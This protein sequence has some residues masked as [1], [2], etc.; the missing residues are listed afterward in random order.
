MYFPFLPLHGWGKRSAIQPQA[1]CSEFP[2]KLARVVCAAMP[3]RDAACGAE[4]SGKNVVLRANGLLLIILPSL[5]ARQHYGCSI[6]VFTS[7]R[8]PRNRSFFFGI[9]RFVIRRGKIPQGYLSNTTRLY[10][11]KLIAQLS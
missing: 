5:Y 4:W 6:H 1:I 8:K 2:W 3:G 7:S 10:A 9:I 11:K